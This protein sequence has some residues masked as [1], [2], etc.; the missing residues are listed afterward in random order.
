MCGVTT[1]EST[2]QLLARAREG[3]QQALEQV[4]ARAIP[5]L[6]RWASGRLPHWARDMVDTDDLV[7][8]TVVSTLKHIDVFEYRVDSALQAYPVSYTH[9]TLPTIYSV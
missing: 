9:L 3:D 6:Q 5:L 4:F 7:Q 2:V 1:P 8:E